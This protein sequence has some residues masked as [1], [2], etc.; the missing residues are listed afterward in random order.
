MGIGDIVTQVVDD[1]ESYKSI[2]EKHGIET[3]EDEFLKNLSVEQKTNV[4]LCKNEKLTETHKIQVND[5]HGE[6]DASSI[7]LSDDEFDIDGKKDVGNPKTKASGEK[8]ISIVPNVVI[9]KTLLET[10]LKIEKIKQKRSNLSRREKRRNMK[11]KKVPKLVIKPLIKNDPLA[12]ADKE[13]TK[14]S[15]DVLPPI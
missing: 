4:N 7:V 6:S 2:L 5:E 10:K 13:K 11:A 14:E 12:D 9:K 15:N 1:V 3:E 8:K